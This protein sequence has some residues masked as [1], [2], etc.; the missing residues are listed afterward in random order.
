MGVKQLLADSVYYLLGG[1]VQVCPNITDH[2]VYCIITVVCV[3][4][5]L[6]YVV[7]RSAA[8]RLRSVNVSI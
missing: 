7:H 4:L 5:T 1:E 3:M 2:S 8:S 6:V